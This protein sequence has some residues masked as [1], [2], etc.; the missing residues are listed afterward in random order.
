MVLTVEETSSRAW[1]VAFSL[2]VKELQSGMPF[3]IYSGAWQQ[4]ALRHPFLSRNEEVLESTKI[5]AVRP[6]TGTSQLGDGHV[7]TSDSSSL[8][9]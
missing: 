5:R 1:T 4:Q 8:M 2:P 9:P 7:F 3:S 6:L